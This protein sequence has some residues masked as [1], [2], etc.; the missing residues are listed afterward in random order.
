[1][2]GLTFVGLGDAKLEYEVTVVVNCYDV[3]SPIP[4]CCKCEIRSFRISKLERIW[5]TLFEFTEFTDTYSNLA[6]Q[7]SEQYYNKFMSVIWL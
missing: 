1:M 7:Y 2:H 6:I 5:V 4:K 3:D